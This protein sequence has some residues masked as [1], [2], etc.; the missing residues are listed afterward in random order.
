M[1][2]TEFRT[3]DR[4]TTI[5][6]FIELVNSN[7]NK[8]VSL[9]SV[10]I[11]NKIENED[12]TKTDKNIKSEVKN[13][14]NRKNKIFFGVMGLMFLFLVGFGGTYFIRNNKESEKVNTI[15]TNNNFDE[16]SNETINTNT[17]K[18]NINEEENDS[19]GSK[20]KVSRSDIDKAREVLYKTTGQNKKDTEFGYIKDDI[21]GEYDSRIKDNYYVFDSSERDTGNMSSIIYLVDKKDYSVY[22]WPVGG[23]LIPY[24]LTKDTS[25]PA[26]QYLM[27]FQYPPNDENKDSESVK[28]FEKYGAKAFAEKIEEI[29]KNADD[30][31]LSYYQDSYVELILSGSTKE[32]LDQYVNGRMNVTPLLQQA[33]YEKSEIEKKNNF[34]EKELQDIYEM[35]RRNGKDFFS[36]KD[37]TKITKEQYINEY[38]PKNS[39]ES[40]WKDGFIK[41]YDESKK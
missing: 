24:E 32:E 34:T 36:I 4:P 25:A 21:F 7:L 18:A 8:T 9:D 14:K 5:D 40:Y 10:N 13:T 39:A 33:A 11:E 3:Q 38:C 30:G 23:I 37:M 41:G 16:N 28:Y 26:Y 27:T 12:T 35:G 1:K 2:A 6:E 22:E 29:F 31:T 20:E 17:E 15:E 19:I